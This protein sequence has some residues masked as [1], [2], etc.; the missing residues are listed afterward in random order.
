MAERWV[1]T[2]RYHDGFARGSGSHRMV[3]ALSRGLLAAV[4][5]GADVGRPQRTNIGD[6]PA[7]SG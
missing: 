3:N 1:T 4:L 2:E 6:P 5:I 7:D